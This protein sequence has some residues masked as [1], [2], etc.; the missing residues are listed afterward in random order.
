MSGFTRGPWEYRPRE[1]DDWGVVRAPD[2]YFIA[3]CSVSR[4]SEDLDKHRAAKTDPSE[5]NARL[6]AACPDGISAA[7]ELDRLTLVILAA[8]NFAD[9]SNLDA[10]SAALKANRDYIAKAVQP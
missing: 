5:A 7:K 2:G 1:H 3:Q 9:R 8:V 10:V 4:W 6:I